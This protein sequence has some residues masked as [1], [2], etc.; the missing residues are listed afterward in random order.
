PTT[1]R[2]RATH[3]PPLHDAL[4][5][6]DVPNRTGE[7][8]A[9]REQGG[10]LQA[11]AG[12]PHHDQHAG[13][14]DEH[15]RPA[16]QSH[17]L[18][19]QERGQRGDEERAGERDRDI[20]GERQELEPVDEAERGTDDGDS[21]DRL[22]RPVV[23]P[24]RREPAGPPG[25]VSHRDQGEETADEQHLADRIDAAERL[26]DRIVEGD[27][28]RAADHARYASGGRGGSAAGGRHPRLPYAWGG[29]RRMRLSAAASI[30][31]RLKS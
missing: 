24:Q 26:D 31:S 9:E 20:V 28:R 11:G 10:P 4:P 12:R 22:P 13:E 23:H 1:R 27:Q 15:G 7:G 2:A 18:A 5:I 30:A 19:E 16:L 14:P 6:S 25:E 8:G 21:A 3:T 29:T 17:N